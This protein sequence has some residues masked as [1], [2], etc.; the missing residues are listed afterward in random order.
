MP[1]EQ[2][3]VTGIRVLNASLD[4][5]IV[6]GVKKIVLRG[7]I[8]PDHLGLLKV[9]DYQ[10]EKLSV[11]P[12]DSL[13]S[14]MKAGETLPDIE[15]GMR[16]GDWV[17]IPDTFDVVIKDKVFLIDGLQRVTHALAF[18]EA[19]ARD[20]RLGAIIHFNTTREW[21][22][23]RFDILNSRRRKVSP[24]VLLRNLREKS[25]AILTL[26]G[27]SN[28]DKEFPLFKR[29]SWSQNM[30]RQE[31][32]SAMT[33]VTVS[34]WLHRHVNGTGRARS[35]EIYTR[36][37]ST[38]ADKITLQK[39]RENVKTFF[40]LIEQTFGIATIEYSA[41][42]CWMRGAFLQVLA[43]LLSDHKDFWTDDDTVLNI[44]LELKR[45]IASF[46]VFD[47]SVIN[48]SGASGRAQVILYGLMLDH[49][50]SG[51][52]TKRLTHRLKLADDLE[53]KRLQDEEQ[54]TADAAGTA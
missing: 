48:L 24:N 6:D 35:A 18:T 15:C 23:D 39:L 3:P 40:T 12:G 27:L 38:T 44:P 7:V 45:K 29:V 28:A 37:L 53:A 43:N 2:E 14:A 30:A 4:E 50:N 10:R 25:P 22:R 11:K 17:E 52:R 19:E 33:L 26:Y 51:K 9:D 13:W 36:N 31:L 20:V 54:E 8:E 16:G 46:P 32:I 5:H 34:M 41:S 49:I 21:E 47:P 1:I 42:A